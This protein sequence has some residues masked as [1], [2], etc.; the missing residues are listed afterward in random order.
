M[1]YDKSKI[2]AIYVACQRAKPS[3]IQ[4]ALHK[5]PFEGLVLLSWL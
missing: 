3:R 4:Q 5:S 1:Y 2:V